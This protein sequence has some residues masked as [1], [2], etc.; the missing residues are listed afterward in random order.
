M[1]F[2]INCILFMS[3]AFTFFAKAYFFQN[4]RKASL[5]LLYCFVRGTLSPSFTPCKGDNIPLDPRNADKEAGIRTVK[6]EDKTLI[7]AII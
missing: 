7:E 3:L 4:V 5:R 6:F 2:T 1:W